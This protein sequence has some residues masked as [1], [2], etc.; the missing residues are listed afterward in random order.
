MDSPTETQPMDVN[1]RRINMKARQQE[2]NDTL[3]LSLK[4]HVHMTGDLHGHTN[5]F[6]SH[7]DTKTLCVMRN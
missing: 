5:K 7:K 3:G 4:E 2:S 1:M 6:L